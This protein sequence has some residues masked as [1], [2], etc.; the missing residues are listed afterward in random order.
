MS[1]LTKVETCVE[2]FVKEKD[3]ERSQK[4]RTCDNHGLKYLHMSTVTCQEQKKKKE[5]R[6]SSISQNLFY[7]YTL[8]P[9]FFE[10]KSIIIHRG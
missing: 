3:F 9:M 8:A 5:L 4:Y 10:V 7:A 1:C 2:V 6:A